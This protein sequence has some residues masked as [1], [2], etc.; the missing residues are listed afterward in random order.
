MCFF[1]HT[2]L[3]AAHKWGVPPA[4]VC[5]SSIKSIS[6]G[7]CE[8]ALCFPMESR[9]PLNWC[10]YVLMGHR[11]KHSSCLFEGPQQHSWSSHQVT[12]QKLLG[13]KRRGLKGNDCWEKSSLRGAADVWEGG[14]EVKVTHRPVLTE[15][16]WPRN[17]RRWGGPCSHRQAWAQSSAVLARVSSQT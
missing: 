16:F 8:G 3:S 1:L 5:C 7:T 4:V 11:W 12:V 14:R 17:L 15:R 10:A 2:P 9:D 13:E 6:E